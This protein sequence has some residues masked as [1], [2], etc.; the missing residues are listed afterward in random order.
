MNTEEYLTLL[1]KNKCRGKKQRNSR[2]IP[3]LHNTLGKIFSQ[4]LT[5]SNRREDRLQ[6]PS[7]LLELP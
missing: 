6:A 5:K 4:E 3:K 7:A 2:Q 1:E